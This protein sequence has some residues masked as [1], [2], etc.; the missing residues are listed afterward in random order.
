MW[1]GFRMLIRRD[2]FCPGKQVDH[3]AAVEY[4]PKDVAIPTSY[5]RRRTIKL[6]MPPHSRE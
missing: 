6:E 2:N 1:F 5:P 4:P 3:R